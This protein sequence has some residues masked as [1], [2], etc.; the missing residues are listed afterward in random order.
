MFSFLL[1]W[2]WPR[3]PKFSGHKHWS[4]ASVIV[5][6]RY[7][8]LLIM[9]LISGDHEY[10]FNASEFLEGLFFCQITA[11]NYDKIIKLNEVF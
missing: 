9:V 4:K 3:P 5:A 1:V 6:I 8:K 2:L 10:I 7:M 11:G